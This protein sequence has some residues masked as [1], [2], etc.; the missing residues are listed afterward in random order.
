MCKP[1]INT[2]KNQGSEMGQHNLSIYFLPY[3]EKVKHNG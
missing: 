2:W 1:A 3:Q